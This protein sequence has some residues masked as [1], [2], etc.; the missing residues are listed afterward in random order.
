MNNRSK[1]KIGFGNFNFFNKMSIF[2]TKLQIS[3]QNVNFLYIML[4]FE[5][6]VLFLDKIH[7]V[8]TIFTFF[9]QNFQF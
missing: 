4:I 9:E 1:I 7:I 6:K 3:R 5:K 2:K 8:W